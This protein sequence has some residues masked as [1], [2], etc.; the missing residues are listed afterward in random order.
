MSIGETPPVS[1]EQPRE[2]RIVI[3]WRRVPDE[4][5]L[6]SFDWDVGPGHICKGMRRPERRQ[7]RPKIDTFCRDGR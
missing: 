3:D 6:G 4:L 2:G 5:G 7:R 1:E